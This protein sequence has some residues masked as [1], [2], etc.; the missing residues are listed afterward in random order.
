MDTI[1]S[2]TFKVYKLYPSAEF[3]T[4]SSKLDLIPDSCYTINGNYLN[5]W[6]LSPK[7]IQNAESIFDRYKSDLDF[8]KSLL[9]EDTK[10]KGIISE[11]K[12]LTHSENE[13]LSKLGYKM[14]PGVGSI[15]FQNYKPSKFIYKCY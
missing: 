4:I 9:N 11:S 12:L 15:I 5:F 10:Q 14:L 3:P 7:G 6:C 1:L 2:K 13:L 8:F